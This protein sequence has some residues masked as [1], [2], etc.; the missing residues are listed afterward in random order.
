MITSD[1]A[2]KVRA[3]QIH[4]RRLLSG[5]QV[6][7]YSTATKGSGFEFD[8]LREYQEGDDIRFIDWRCSAR[9]N[10]LYVRQYLQERNRT[11]MLLVDNSPS[12][13]Y[14]STGTL[15]HET[16]SLVTGVFALVAD[17]G[18]DFVGVRTTAGLYMPPLR[19]SAHVFQLTARV[20]AQQPQPGVSFEQLVRA[21]LATKK[22]NMV[23]VLVSDFIDTD[24]SAYVPLCAGHE[25]I[26]VRCLDELALAFP[27][28]GFLHVQDP[29]TMQ[30][31]LLDTRSLQP[32]LQQ[33]V[34]EQNMQMRKYAVDLLSVSPQR[35]VISDMITFFKRRMVY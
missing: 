16:I 35:P 28:G 8:Q 22:K 31:Y 26:A 7:E 10:R 13:R 34:H 23:L 32:L 19:G 2:A 5:M 18:K 24:V 14:G 21:V 33:R 15:V 20:Y 12:T 29:E 6:G 4:T 11:I 9:M 1:I 30:R 17:Y 27:P 3:I 25:L